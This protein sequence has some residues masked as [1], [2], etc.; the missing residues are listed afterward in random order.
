[1]QEPQ[2]SDHDKQNKNDS[3]SVSRGGRFDQLAEYLP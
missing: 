2:Q 1:M 3:K